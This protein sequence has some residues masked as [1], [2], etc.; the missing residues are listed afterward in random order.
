MGVDIREAKTCLSHLIRCSHLICSE[1]NLE[2]Y[3]ENKFVLKMVSA[4]TARQFALLTLTTSSTTELYC[5]MPHIASTEM[6]ISISI[7]LSSYL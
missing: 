2:I 3:S 6:F 7:S 4:V 1:M 5:T